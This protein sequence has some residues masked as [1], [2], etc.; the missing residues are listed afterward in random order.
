MA[1]FEKGVS[2]NPQGRPRGSVNR[3]VEEIRALIRESV[4]WEDLLQGVAEKARE[5]N[6]P[7]MKL[8]LEYAYG[9]PRSMTEVENMEL[10]K[11]RDPIGAFLEDNPL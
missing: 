2:G 10:F 3:S 7:A 4:D 9:V 8:L 6:V 11:K 5:G 1:K